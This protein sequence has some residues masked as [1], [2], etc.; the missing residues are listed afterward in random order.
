[1][2]IST[3]WGPPSIADSIS[4]LGDAITGALK[5]RQVAQVMSNLPRTPSGAVDYEAAAQALMRVDPKSAALLMQHAQQQQQFG[6]QQ[7]Q[8]TSTEQHQRATEQLQRDQLAALEQQRR[9]Q[10]RHQEDVLYKPQ[11]VERENEDGEKET[12]LYNPR[13]QSM[14]RIDIPFAK[15]PAPAVPPATSTVPQPQKRSD[16]QQTEGPSL[17]AETGDQPAP[18]KPAVATD[19]VEPPAAAGQQALPTAKDI[20]WLRTHPDQAAQFDKHFNSPGAAAAFLGAPKDQVDAML[21]GS[22]TRTAQ[23]PPEQP[24]AQAPGTP[25]FVVPPGLKKK[26]YREAYTKEF[27]RKRAD[28]IAARVEAARN[29][30]GFMPSV[31]GAMEAYKALAEGNGIGPW[32]GNAISQAVQRYGTSNPMLENTSWGRMAKM[33]DA[34][35][36]HAANLKLMQAQILMK[37]QG[38]ISDNERRLL[39]MTLPELDSTNPQAGFQR[40]QQMVETMQRI[41]SDAQLLGQ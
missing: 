40:L 6:L 17:V 12:F 33:R 24:P 25:G 19:T 32:Q 41:R 37:G 30:E 10:Q 20:A 7:R 13:D 8:F 1:M 39:S 5:D 29:V 21:S 3:N 16:I 23:Q 22:D 4:G 36:M 38:A 11:I 15:P 28:T 14:K 9:E 34:Y 27:A 2:P 18:P 26:E 35:N 31:T